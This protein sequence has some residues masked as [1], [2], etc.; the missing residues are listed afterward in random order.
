M[1]TRDQLYLVFYL[2]ILSFCGVWFWFVQTARSGAA[3]L[4]PTDWWNTLS[5]APY[6]VY[7]TLTDACGNSP[8]RFVH[9]LFKSTV[10]VKPT[11]GVHFNAADSCFCLVASWF[12]THQQTFLHSW[13]MPASFRSKKTIT[14]LH[15]CICN[16]C[17]VKL[18]KS[19]YCLEN[20]C[21]GYL[22]ILFSCCFFRDIFLLEWQYWQK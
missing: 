5:I 10:G 4:V 21:V 16:L 17:H 12:A 15:V 9:E 13:A 19:G 7:L 18:M 22:L 3:L 11:S 2:Y 8:C 1:A 20:I 14:H 6:L